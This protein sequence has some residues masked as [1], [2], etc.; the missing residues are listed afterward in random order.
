MPDISTSFRDDEWE[1]IKE[2]AELQGLTVEEF[3]SHATN[4]LVKN[5]KEDA[6]KRIYNP[7]APK[8]IK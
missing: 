5:I 2:A 6:R 4:R 3:V 8:I 7:K 1:T